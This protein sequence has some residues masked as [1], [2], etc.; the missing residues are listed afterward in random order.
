MVST[1]N[2][3]N[4]E[5]IAMFQTIQKKMEEMRQKG[6]EDQKRNEEKVRILK[7]QNEELKRKLDES[8]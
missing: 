3:T 6:I 1:R 5:Q 8:E 2:T 7:Q 4:E